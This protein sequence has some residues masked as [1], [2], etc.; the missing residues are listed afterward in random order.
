MR[1]MPLV[2]A[3]AFAVVLDA[4]AEPPKP[5][6]LAAEIER[7][8]A[9]LR[10]APTGDPLWAQIK[11]GAEPAL[12]GAREALGQGR[13]LL[14]LQRFARVRGDLA[15]ARY[16]ASQSAKDRQDIAAFEAEWRRRQAGLA[17]PVIAD[18]VRPALLRAVAEAAAAQAPVYARASLDY[19][20]STNAESGYY[21]LG[22]AAAGVELAGL[23]P[24]LSWDAPGRPPAL[25]DLQPEIDAL[26]GEL[27]AAYRPPASLDRHGD[28]IAT[29]ALLKEAAE[30][31]ASGHRHA[32]LLRYLQAAQ[33][34]GPLA[35]PVALDPV[36]LSRWED[37]LGAASVDHSIGRLFLEAAQAAPQAEGR[38]IAG[39]VLPRYFQALEP[40][41]A[42]PAV[43]AAEVTVTLVRWPYT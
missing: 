32:A 2:V 16:V 28:F 8:S 11:P 38:A 13:R 40:G 20:R 22:A 29:S 18:G 12:A 26:R 1:A 33:R 37:R 43:A 3:L 42:R 14:A 5:D 41:R 6:A 19:A 15:A 7:W 23:A 10:D 39:H 27:L 30:H 17:A 9:V 31:N 4:R 24:S 36:P 35:A 21:Y 34:I 25:R